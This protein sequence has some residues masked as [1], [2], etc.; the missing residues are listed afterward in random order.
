MVR[1][2]LHLGKKQLA[3]SVRPMVSNLNF[4]RHSP[5]ACPALNSGIVQADAAIVVVAVARQNL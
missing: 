2:H 3:P 4:C 5:L 1:C